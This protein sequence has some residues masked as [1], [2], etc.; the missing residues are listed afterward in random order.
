MYG[1]LADWSL[2]ANVLLFGAVVL[3]MGF[4]G[5]PLLVWAVVWGAFLFSWGV[6]LIPGLIL[7]SPFLVFL[8]PPIRSQL[9]S[10]NVMR[11]LKK[12]GMIPAISETEKTAV[13]AGTTWVEADLFSGKPD[14]D[15]ILNEPYLFVNEEE[16]AFLDNQVEHLCSLVD[17]HDATEKGDISP[18]TWAYLKKEKFFGMIIPKEYGGLGF[19]A[20][21]HS[22]VVAK[23]TSHSVATAITVMVPNSL[24]PAELILHYGTDEQKK[25]YLP[26]LAS[27]EEIPCFG[28]T[29]LSAGS[30]AGSMTSKGI[31]FKDEDGSLKIRLDFSKRYIT[32]SAVSTVIGLAVKLF[33]PDNL[34]GQGEDLG[35][36]CILVPSKAEGVTL[37]RRHDPLGVP[38]YNCPIDGKD[39]VLSIDNVIGGK[40]GC[41]KGW[42]MLMESLAAGRSISLPSQTAGSVQAVA[43]ATGAYAAVRKQFGISIGDFEGIHEALAEIGANTYLNE[44]LRRFTAGAVDKGLK[45]AVASAI[46]KYNAT[47]IGRQT[48]VHAMDVVGGAGISLGKRNLIAKHYNVA[49]IAVTVEGANILTRTMIIFGQGAI[50]CHPYAW[51]ELQALEAGDVKAFDSV[52]SAHVGHIFRNACRALLLT[53]TRGRLA[54]TP[55]SPIKSVYRRLAWSSASFA[56]LSDIALGLYGGRLKFRESITGRFADILSWMYLITASARRFEAEGGQ[57]EHEAFIHYIAAKGFSEIQNAFDGIYQNIDIPVGKFIFSKLIAAWSRLNTMAI[58]FDDQNRREISAV[59]TTPGAARDSITKIA[60]YAPK[61]ADSHARLLEEAFL[62]NADA[63]AISRKVSRAAKKKEIKKAK[64]SEMAKEAAEKSI[65]SQEELDILGKAHE[66]ALEAM[67][68]DEFDIHKYKSGSVNLW[69]SESEKIESA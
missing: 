55:S 22:E 48:A 27:G 35:I 46:A 61:E 10:A 50:R 7:L 18:A 16:R 44:A 30:D 59:L 53:L 69:K 58:P 34:L 40:D 43:R 2:V 49:P 56:F 19:S 17:D 23:V 28:L 57:K 1:F 9:F 64:F 68:V 39:V 67:K 8:I 5:V 11:T 45:P 62:A 15:A 47:E 6:G 66:L 52:F 60:Y 4:Y 14:F 38:F 42:R 33:D 32:L 20:I 65:I 54:N 3:A 26:R 21:A 36:T 29:E 31:V 12:L 37:G 63:A 25:H 13:E 51:K 24:G 41:G